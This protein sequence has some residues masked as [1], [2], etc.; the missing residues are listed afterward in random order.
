LLVVGLT[1]C[2]QGNELAETDAA[3]IN[4]IFKTGVSFDR[5]PYVRAETFRVI[6]ILAD[7]TLGTYAS[8]GLDDLVPMVRLASLRATLASKSPDAASASARVF[9]RGSNLE[10]HV[11][12]GAVAEYDDG[13]NRRELLGRALRSSDA[14]LRQLAFR[15]N[16][17]ERV[18]KAAAA[19]DDEAL[20][21]NLYPELG[22]YVGLEKDPVLAGLAIRKFLDLGQNDRIEPLLEALQDDRGALDRRLR[23]ARILS[24]AKAAEAEPAF[25]ALIDAHTKVMNDD[26]LG[27]PDDIVP[28][29]LLRAAIL[30]TVASGSTKNVQ[31]AQSYINNV[32]EELA[33][34]VLDSFSHNPSQDAAL[35]LKVAMQDSRRNVRLRAIELYQHREDAD[36]GALIG[37]LKGSDYE[38]QR[39]LSQVLFARFL[40]EWVAALEKQ[41]YRTSEM[42]GT[43]A[44]LR[45]VV[46]NQEEASNLLAPLQKVLQQIQNSEEG[47][48]ASLAAYLLA[49]ASE[50][51]GQVATEKLDDATRYA[52]LEYLVRTSPEKHVKTFR[53]YLYN[54]LF[55]LRLMSAAGLWRA[56]GSSETQGAV[57]PD[58]DAAPPT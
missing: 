51:K 33:I 34:E 48:R 39:R 38:T 36:A 58:T 46:T 19:K 26:S 23:A 42:E 32:A 16:V 17:L 22:R 3:A 18:D 56:L 27:V 31:V 7:P 20:K 37:A 10:K 35:T 25:Q 29:A 53:K 47:T 15:A 28:P 45:D 4:T 55:V 49:I 13:P 2:P 50:D 57:A 41:L 12:L 14:G 9:S 24:A 43:L 1:G 52:Y 8:E 5:D 30:G 6:E 21:N 11:V 44:L 40:D 54:D